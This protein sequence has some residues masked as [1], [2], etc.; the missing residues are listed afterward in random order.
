LAPHFELFPKGQPQKTS[1]IAKEC[2]R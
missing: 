1:K 2:L